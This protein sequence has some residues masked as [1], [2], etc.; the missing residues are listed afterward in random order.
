MPLFYLRPF[1][2][3]ADKKQT[4]RVIDADLASTIPWIVVAVIGL[5]L[6]ATFVVLPMLQVISETMP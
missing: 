3:H 2:F 5:G 4:V 1:D 6:F